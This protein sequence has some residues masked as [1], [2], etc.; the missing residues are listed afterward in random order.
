MVNDC[1]ELLSG[2]VVS[3]YDPDWG[4]VRSVDQAVDQAR[5]L[6]SRVSDLIATYTGTPEQKTALQAA[7]EQLCNRV[8]ATAST[9]PDTQSQQ[10]TGACQT[11]QI[12][13]TTFLAC[14]VP[15]NTTATAG[16]RIATVATSCPIT[17]DELFDDATDLENRLT[18]TESLVLTTG[19]A[20]ESAQTNT[21]AISLTQVTDVCQQAVR[22]K[23]TPVPNLINNRQVTIDGIT[24]IALCRCTQKSGD[25]A[26]NGL[27]NFV[28]ISA[29]EALKKESG[30]SRVNIKAINPAS[31]LLTDKYSNWINATGAKEFLRSLTALNI[32]NLDQAKA[33]AI[34][35]LIGEMKP[36]AYKLYQTLTTPSNPNFIT[37]LYGEI[38]TEWT[39]AALERALNAYQE[40]VRVLVPTLMAQVGK[41]EPVALVRGTL[42]QFGAVEYATLKPEERCLAITYLA[43]RNGTDAEIN[44]IIYYTPETSGP[45]LLNCFTAKSNYVFLKLLG[46]NVL[47]NV[48]TAFIDWG[49]APDWRGLPIFNFKGSALQADQGAGISGKNLLLMERR[50]TDGYLVARGGMYIPGKG[51]EI[52]PSGW[53]NVYFEEAYTI[54]GYTLQAERVWPMPSPYLYYL[55]TRAKGEQFNKALTLYGLAVGTAFGVSELIAAIEVG[56]TGLIVASGVDLAL[57]ADLYADLTLGAGVEKALRDSGNESWIS[58]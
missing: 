19:T 34:A 39:L 49:K 6:L 51:L 22:W 11:F 8:A 41:P 56:N 46:H 30:S 1:Y 16:A 31:I 57:T 52:S 47:K 38:T 23:T 12:N 3:A 27:V 5:E 28:E 17:Q 33:T 50:P 20:E 14:T 42:S 2:T 7:G 58:A 44:D 18:N 55:L 48:A 24:Y 10:L 26:P 29:Y 36:E 15:T 13:L 43:E 54:D 21:G 25:C 4:G 40:R 45:Q 32:P 9:L 37:Y 53:V 35:D